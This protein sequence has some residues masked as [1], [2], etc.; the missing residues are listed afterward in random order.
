[1]T[2][3]H[4]TYS[5]QEFIELQDEMQHLLGDQLLLDSIVAYFGTD[6]MTKCLAGILNDWNILD[7]FVADGFLHEIEVN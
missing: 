3:V 1:M 5:E 6:E 4:R 2:I 7:V